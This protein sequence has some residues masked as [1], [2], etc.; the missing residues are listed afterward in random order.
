MSH[1]IETHCIQ[2]FFSFFDYFILFKSV[3]AKITSGKEFLWKIIMFVLNKKQ[4]AHTHIY[5]SLLHIFKVNKHHF[6]SIDLQFH[7]I[8]KVFLSLFFSFYS[9][10]LF[11]PR[12]IAVRLFWYG[13]LNFSFIFRT[14]SSNFVTNF[15]HQLLS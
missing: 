12:C 11:I 1:T 13:Y 10:C 6:L 8:Y 4:H 5:I 3:L 2:K 14:S 9:F 7:T 15:L